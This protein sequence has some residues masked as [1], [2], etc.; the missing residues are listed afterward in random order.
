MSNQ[1]SANRYAKAL[2]DVALKE[3][4]D[5]V[6][7]ERDLAA[8]ADLFATHEELRRPLT[9][10]V[11]PVRAKRAV[12]EQ[13]VTRMQPSPIVAKL[14]LLL[15]DRDRLELLPDLM[16]AYRERL[17]DHQNVVR[18]E[19]V[20]TIPLARERA[21]VLQRKLAAVTGRTVNLDTRVDPSILGGLVA[22]V[23]TVVYDG[24]LATQLAKMKERLSENR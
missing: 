19:V 18:A 5:P 21:A 1:A 3:E 17:M 22:R 12:I 9:N 13:L 7:I 11:V 8:F 23:G 6:T 15:A 10:P 14:M 4:A 16:N 2:L 20:S 24:S